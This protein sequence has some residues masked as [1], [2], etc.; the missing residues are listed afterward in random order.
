MRTPYEHSVKFILRSAVVGLAAL[1]V[2]GCAGQR[3]EIQSAAPTGQQAPAKWEANGLK[4]E[5]IK[6][7]VNGLMLDLR[8]RIT[9][10]EKARELVKKSTPLQSR[11][12]TPM[13]S[14]PPRTDGFPSSS[15][16]AWPVAARPRR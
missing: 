5:R 15:S 11:T 1:T 7:A 6:P 3:Q 8:Y 2:S 9:D 4:V 12:R 16:N 10:P 14:R 13:A